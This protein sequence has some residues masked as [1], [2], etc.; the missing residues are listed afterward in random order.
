[1]DRRGGLSVKI[2][3]ERLA[4]YKS[5]SL[6][7]EKNAIKEITQELILYALYHSGFFKHAAF[8]GGT[9]LRILYGL[10]RFSEDLDFALLALDPH[11]QLRPHL[12]AA[13]L[14]LDP[15]G[16]KLEVAP[17]SGDGAVQGGFLKDDALHQLL[18]LQHKTP[19]GPMRTLKI[20]VE[21]DINPPSG[22][23]VESRF[24][25]FPL[26]FMVTTHD[27]PSLFAGKSHALLCRKFVKGRDWF[28]FLWYASRSVPLNTNLLEAALNQHG[29]WQGTHLTIDLNWFQ[30]EMLSKIRMINW[31]ETARD[32]KRFLRP[33][34]AKTLELWSVDFFAHAIDRWYSSQQM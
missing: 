21:I 28:D 16:Y 20:K 34:D 30:R 17:I 25:D 1:M 4:P 24:H 23:G 27:L 26:N 33:A 32:V 29:P 12:E 22:A 8:Q 2:I 7:E 6:Q 19:T 18:T 9:C 10:P 11:F 15:Y 31:H 5:S 13:K 14:F 3:Q